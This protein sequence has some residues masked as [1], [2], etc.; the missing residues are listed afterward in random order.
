MCLTARDCNVA[1]LFL[2]LY[3]PRPSLSSLASAAASNHPSASWLNAPS[4]PSATTPWHKFGTNVN[5]HITAILDVN[6]GALL[7]GGGRYSVPIDMLTLQDRATS[8]FR[9]RVLYYLGTQVDYNTNSMGYRLITPPYGY[10]YNSYDDDDP[11]WCTLVRRYA[12]FV[13]TNI[14]V[15]TFCDGM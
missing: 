6:G 8:T 13:A 3:A 2:L 4:S 12:I 1:I 9:Q 10:E 7:S 14:L 15:C 11:W 5:Y